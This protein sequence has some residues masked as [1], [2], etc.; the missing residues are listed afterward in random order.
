[1][2]CFSLGVL[3]V[4]EE[5]DEGRRCV[6]EGDHMTV[7]SPFSLSVDGHFLYIFWI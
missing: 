4:V 1:M 2:F 6:H 3:L 7:V 5:L